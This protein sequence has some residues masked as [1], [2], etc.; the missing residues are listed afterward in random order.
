VKDDEW[1]KARE[2]CRRLKCNIKTVSKVAND[3]DLETRRLS[4][5]DVRYR[6]S[7]IVNALAFAHPNKHNQRWINAPTTKVYDDY[8]KLNWDEFICACDTHSPHLNEKLF[9]RMLEVA[10][11]YKIKNF[12]HPGDFFDE[13]TFSS[14]DVDAEDMV[15]WDEEINYSRKILKALKGVFKNNYFSMGSHDIRFWRMMLKQSKVTHF[16]L[17]FKMTGVDGINV[18]RYRFAEINHEWR[19]T[20]P[21]N[22]VKVGGLPAV[23]LAAKFNRSIVFGHGH[24]AGI[25]RD[26]SGKHYLVAPG[27]LCDPKRLAYVNLWDTSHDM[28]TCAFLVVVEKTKPIL[29]FE[30]S[31]WQ[32]YLK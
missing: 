32:V 14:F 23:R 17:P 31:P 1:L 18:S 2:I 13:N 5:H 28:M 12:I 22:V 30:D 11:K 29:F 7:D 15:G 20:H 25:T 9:N 16:D 26:P 27:C 24:W 3:N 21:K 19:L 4:Y 8:W 10:E 6:L